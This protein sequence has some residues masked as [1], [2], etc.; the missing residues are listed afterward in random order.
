M[1]ATLA[2]FEGLSAKACKERWLMYKEQLI[3]KDPTS[4]TSFQEQELFW[5]DP[6]GYTQFI[7]ENC[8]HEDRAFVPHLRT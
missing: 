5:H 8:K 6:S 7:A 1:T 4:Y 2:I 3:E